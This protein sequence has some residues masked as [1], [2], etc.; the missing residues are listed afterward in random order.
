MDEL[1]DGNEVKMNPSDGNV[2][3]AELSAALIQVFEGCELTAYQD[4][5]GVWTIGFGHTGEVDGVPVGLGMTIT[6]QQ[7]EDL[8]AQDQA[9]L[10]TLVATFPVLEGAAL[11]SFGYN[12]GVS[13]LKKVI[14][15]QA[16][17]TDFIH[18]RKG[19]ILPGL[20][21]RRNLEEKLIL[22]SQQKSS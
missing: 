16:I 12:L 20:V 6:Q 19:H 2:G 10:F 14:A 17:L 1:Y 22:V 9:H 11:V 8:L 7:A 5:G 4:T 18:D 15:G 3:L 13:N 21:A